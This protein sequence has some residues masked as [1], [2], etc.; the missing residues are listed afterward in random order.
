MSPTSSRVNVLRHDNGSRW[1]SLI[2]LRLT[3]YQSYP[4]GG[5]GGGALFT[6][7]GRGVMSLQ[8][9]RTYGRKVKTLHLFDVFMG[10]DIFRRFP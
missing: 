6:S 7:I 2:S 3:L 4:E 9:V 8:V 5:G 10:F 1:S